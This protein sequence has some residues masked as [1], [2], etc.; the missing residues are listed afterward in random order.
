[1][2]QG[3][4][5]V[6]PFEHRRGGRKNVGHHRHTLA[7]KPQGVVGRKVGQA[8]LGAKQ[9]V[10]FFHHVRDAAQVRAVGGG[11]VGRAQALHARAHLAAV[12]AKG[13]RGLGRQV[14]KHHRCALGLQVVGHGGP[15]QRGV[16]PLRKHAGHTL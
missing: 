12:L 13:L 11:G 10:V 3:G 16:G 1:M 8:G 2:A 6:H 14:G 15:E 9:K 5:A 4:H 7:G